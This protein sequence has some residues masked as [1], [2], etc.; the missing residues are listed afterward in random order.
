MQ[1]LPATGARLA[2]GLGL[3]G[4]SAE[5]LY[6]PAVNLE[7]GTSHLAAS[8]ERHGGDLVRA[9]AAYNAGESRVAAWVTA[10]PA[11]DRDL[12]IE[13][14]PFAETRDYVRVVQRNIALYR[15]LYPS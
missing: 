3:T 7:F 15:A 6:D 4:W 10:V 14:I 11:D 9:L 5:Q 8:L 13:R 1:V 12:F 2:K